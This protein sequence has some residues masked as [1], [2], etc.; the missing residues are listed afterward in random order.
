MNGQRLSFVR[1]LQRANIAT[2]ATCNAGAPITGRALK[3][4]SP[5][6]PTRLAMSAIL[7]CLRQS[8]QTAFGHVQPFALS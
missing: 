7:L 3:S 6:S 5:N 8:G 4:L 2:V 1:R